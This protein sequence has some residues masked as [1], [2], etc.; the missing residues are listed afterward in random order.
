[1]WSYLIIS[2]LP[3]KQMSLCLQYYDYNAELQH[4][5]NPPPGDGGGWGQCGYGEQHGPEPSG[6]QPPAEGR[7]DRRQLLLYDTAPNL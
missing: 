5:S 3:A 1:M 6:V 2:I 4:V 7:C